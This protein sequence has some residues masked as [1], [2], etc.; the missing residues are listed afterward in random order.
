MGGLSR[1]RQ[2]ALPPADRARNGRQG[3]TTHPPP[4]CRRLRTPGSP[5][6]DSRQRRLAG[7]L[8][9]AG[10]PSLGLLKKAL[11]RLHAGAGGACW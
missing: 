11:A 9:L 8:C 4:E 2:P 7:F 6:G 3:A 10:A 1:T 5:E